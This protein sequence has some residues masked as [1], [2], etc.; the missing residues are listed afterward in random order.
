MFLLIAQ[1]RKAMQLL[2]TE[3]VPVH[4]QQ[5]LFYDAALIDP[6]PDATPAD[7]AR[8]LGACAA[9]TGT[10]VS[11]QIFDW[12]VKVVFRSLYIARE[13]LRQA[14]IQPRLVYILRNEN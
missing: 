9:L 8:Q 10:L 4:G 14:N 3:R 5:G 12:R 6:M 7:F 11:V 1:G 13:L 2:S